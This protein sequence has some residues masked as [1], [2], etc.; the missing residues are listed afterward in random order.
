MQGFSVESKT[1]GISSSSTLTRPW[2]PVQVMQWSKHD[3]KKPRDQAREDEKL[4]GP[5]QKSAE[6]C[7]I[8]SFIQFGE[9]L[10]TRAYMQKGEG[11]RRLGNRRHANEAGNW[12]GVGPGRSA[13][14][15]P[16]PNRP[17]FDLGASRAIYSPLTESHASSHSSS[18]AEEQRREGHR[19]GEDRVEM[20]D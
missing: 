16:G 18:A 19:S 20:V 9:K 5:G 13:R 14:P 1:S 3:S 10:T 8:R 2:S 15:I 11:S 12:A 4:R 7:G 6:S 17:P